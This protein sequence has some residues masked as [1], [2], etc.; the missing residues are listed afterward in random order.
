MVDK[1]FDEAAAN[2]ARSRARRA[3]LGVAEATDATSPDGGQ[4]AVTVGE[5]FQLLVDTVED[6]AIITLDPSG[7]VM[8]WNEGARRLK[9]YDADE[10]LG[11]HFA[12]F[13][14]LEDIERGKAQAELAVARERGRFEEE[15]WRVRKG[16]ARYWARVTLVALRHESGQIR[17]FA[18]ITQD[19]TARERARAAESSLAAA[20]AHLAAAEEARTVAETAEGHLRSLIGA[21]SDGYFALDDRWRFTFVNRSLARLLGKPDHDL[22]GGSLWDEVGDSI[23][24]NFFKRLP[25]LLT[26]APPVEFTEFH[27]PTQHWFAVNARYSDGQIIVFV[28]DVTAEH[29][30]GSG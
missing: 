14:P 7:R 27:S 6:R 25:P 28:R 21:M 29:Q 18:K 4:D 23:H 26:G 1:R 17:G 20:E 9:G 2:V 30:R 5:Q 8:S 16:G 11:R 12:L 22:I 3:R 15:G 19:L 13:Y 24:S 10:V